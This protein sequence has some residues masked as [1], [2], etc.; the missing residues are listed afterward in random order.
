MCRQKHFLHDY[1]GNDVT[2]LN[3]PFTDLVRFVV[4]YGV[5][6]GGMASC[7]GRNVCTYNRHYQLP[8][9]Y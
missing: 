7:V 2:A 4:Q 9:S 3:C 5:L 1:V 8:D 6:Y